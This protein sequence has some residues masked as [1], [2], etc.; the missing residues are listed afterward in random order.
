MHVYQVLTVGR[1]LKLVRAEHVCHLVAALRTNTT[2]SFQGV[3]RY[4]L[5]TLAEISKMYFRSVSFQ[6]DI[7]C[8]DYEGE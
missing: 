7:T 2:Y 3:F 5:F 8:Y 1:Q 4:I 6:D